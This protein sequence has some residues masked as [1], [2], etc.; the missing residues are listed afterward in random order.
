[1]AR[2]ALSAIVLALAAIA[3]SSG[4]ARAQN[5]A[6]ARLDRPAI[7]R[8]THDLFL[9]A[10]VAEIG[11]QAA[12]EEVLRKA[13]LHLAPPEVGGRLGVGDPGRVWRGND[14]A[15]PLA[16]VTRDSGI[17]CQVMAPYADVETSAAL[18]RR[19]AEELRRPGQ[20]VTLERDEPAELGGRP[21][22]QVFFRVGPAPGG[23][24][25]ALSV[26]DARPGGLGLM[27][28]ASRAA[29]EPR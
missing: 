17:L 6:P 28:T 15:R 3:L 16:V 21:G 26:A 8:A 10:C 2:P 14:P 7:S 23:L 18:F 4:Q 1:M 12:I 25:L 24:L 11:D 27:M 5:Q 9:R 13:D 20:E 19:A 22:R 29:P